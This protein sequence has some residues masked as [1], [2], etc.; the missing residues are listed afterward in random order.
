MTPEIIIAFAAGLMFGIVVCF[1]FF[2]STA[3]EKS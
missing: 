3:K 1:I 2:V